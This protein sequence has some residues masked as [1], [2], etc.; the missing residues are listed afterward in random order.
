MQNIKF[1]IESQKI[2]NINDIS[3]IKIN[4]AFL[5]IKFINY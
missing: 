3:R 5:F 2:Y 1:D 4:I